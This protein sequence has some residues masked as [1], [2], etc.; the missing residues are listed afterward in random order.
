M[1]T[2][3]AARSPFELPNDHPWPPPRMTEEEFLPWCDEDIRA[4]WVDGGSCRDVTDEQRA[5]R[6][7]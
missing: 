1:S 4:Q 2:T 6:S 3:P 7:Q 5:Y